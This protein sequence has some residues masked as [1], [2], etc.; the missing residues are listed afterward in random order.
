MLNDMR[1][2]L[3]AIEKK[4]TLTQREVYSDVDIYLTVAANILKGGGAPIDKRYKLD[5]NNN[6]PFYPPMDNWS[7]QLLIK[8]LFGNDEKVL[9]ILNEITK[10]ELQ[11]PPGKGTQIYGSERFIDYS[12]F[13][14]RGHYL[15]TTY[16]KRYFRMLMW[17]GRMDCGFN[18]LPN[19]TGSP[20]NKSLRECRD[21][22]L[23]TKLLN[24]TGNMAKLDDIRKIISFMIGDEDSFSPKTLLTIIKN[25]NLDIETLLKDDTALNKLQK[26]IKKSPLAKQMIR[27][28]VVVSDPTVSKQVSSPVVLQ[29]FGQRFA[30]DSFVLNKVTF[31]SIIFKGEK[32]ARFKPKGLDV[33]AALGNQEALKLLTPELEKYY[34]SSNLFSLISVINSLPE[35]FWNKTIYS[36]WLESLRILD[37]N[38]SFIKNIPEAMKT[39]AWQMK[40]LQTQLSS[41]SQLR[42][43]TQLYVKQPYAAAPGCEYPIAYVE[44]YPEFYLKLAEYANSAIK[45]FSSI[46]YDIE[47]ADYIKMSQINYFKNFASVMKKLQLMSE[48][49]LNAKP[50]SKEE[51]IFFKRTIDYKSRSGGANYDGWYCDLFYNRFWG[52]HQKR[53][54]SNNG[55]DLAYK[56]APEISD[57][58]TNPSGGNVLETCVGN[59]EF[60]II[61]ID[62]QNYRNIYVGPVYSYYEFWQPVEK[63][64]NDEQWQDILM[65]KTN[66]KR[67]QWSNIFQ[68]KELTQKQ[69]LQKFK[70]PDVIDSSNFYQ[71][72]YL[73]SLNRNSPLLPIRKEL[74]KR[75]ENGQIKLKFDEELYKQIDAMISSSY[76][77]DW[78]LLLFYEKNYNSFTKALKCLSLNV[79]NFT[80]ND[81]IKAFN[82]PKYIDINRQLLKQAKPSDDM[83]FVKVI[84]DF[85]GY[86]KDKASVPVLLSMLDNYPAIRKN[87]FTSLRMI[88]DKKVT[89][90][91][92]KFLTSIYDG[93]VKKVKFKPIGPHDI[94][95]INIRK[96]FSYAFITLCALGDQETINDAKKFLNGDNKAIRK[97]YHNYLYRE[98]V[99]EALIAY[100]NRGKKPSGQ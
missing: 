64:L 55:G 72:K 8:S 63:R 24:D 86:Y 99:Q 65:D 42:H 70:Y 67:P 17:F 97:K 7:G 85:T 91:I 95:C 13:I 47:D 52:K 28:Q 75:I 96:Y 71:Y 46:K 76:Q 41:W 66:I 92:K 22:I 2:E 48:K 14:P 18:I 4:S 82:K 43:D 58:F 88:D 23:I 90:E 29:F 21:A 40:Q 39:Y 54:K 73:F 51:E 35:S 59:V 50:F 12:Q 37:K 32:I 10:H 5:E 74:K 11:Q 62:S 3:V 16:L 93:T 45:L 87:I 68:T 19:K 84:V 49:E 83:G 69:I 94:R 30:I 61:A 81:L 80:V 34:Y 77:V 57:V 27:S 36:R 26:A 9:Y 78:Q 100:E 6:D 79:N 38:I 1:K 98:T 25:E 56:W 31:D 53:F 44:P 89:Q 33:M 15:K 60:M 20:E